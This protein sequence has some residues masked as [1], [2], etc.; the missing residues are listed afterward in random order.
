MK[1]FDAS[2][3]VLAIV[4]GL[5]I[6]IGLTGWRRY[7][8]IRG[9]MLGLQKRR[10]GLAD[11]LADA[12]Y[13]A[14][15]KIPPGPLPLGGGNDPAITIGANQDPECFTLRQVNESRED[16]LIHICDWPSMRSTIE[17]FQ[18]SRAPAAE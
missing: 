5:A 3:I 7:W 4:A 8:R 9:Y 1:G 18:Q 17:T 10:H 11:L 14:A 2:G 12:G 16:D 15:V 6:G 13:G